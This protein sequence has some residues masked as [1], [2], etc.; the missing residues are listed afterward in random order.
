MIAVAGFEQL[1]AE[2]GQ[3]EAHLG[4]ALASPV[5]FIDGLGRFLHQAKGK[6]L[7]P[8]LAVLFYKLL[9]A[10]G[11][12]DGLLRLAAVLE[13]I[14]LATLVHDDVIDAAEQRR[15]QPTLHVQTSNQVAVLE[16]DHLFVQVFKE[17]NDFPKATRTFVIDTVEKI[18]Q[19]ELLQ[20]SLRGRVP[21]EADYNAV[22][23]GKTAALIACACQIGTRFG[24]PDLPAAR[25]VQV[26]QAGLL[27]GRAFQLID[28][29]LDVFGD[30]ALGKPRW[31]DLRGGWLT[32]PFIRLLDEQPQWADLLL[33]AGDD[34]PTREQIR[35][36]LE[37]LNLRQRLEAEA[38]ALLDLALAKLAWLPDVP[39]KDT[40]FDTIDFIARRRS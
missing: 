26:G 9:G 22:V 39:L 19:G 37:A 5:P 4:R 7:R 3:V 33:E 16:G 20:E 21:G 14:H 12:Q 36:A 15:S 8:A 30:E 23:A 35:R 24:D 38:G 27:M 10:R 17:I 40:L 28:D 34:A 31:A 32:L 6:R 2:L 11:E 29:V 25:G 18:L 1:E 13:L